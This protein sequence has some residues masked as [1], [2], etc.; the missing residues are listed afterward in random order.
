MDPGDIVLADRGFNVRDDLAIRQVK[1][2]M[3]ASTKGKQQ[4]SQEEVEMSRRLSRFRIHVERVIGQLRKKYKL[5]QGTLPI[6]LIKR[7]TD[8]TVTT[9]EC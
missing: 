3:P 1:L 9:I 4:L 8:T 7:P 2:E 5:L 6:S